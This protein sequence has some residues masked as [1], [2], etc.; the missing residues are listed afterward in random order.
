MAQDPLIVVAATRP[1]PGEASN[2]DAWQVDWQEGRCRVAIVDGLGHGPAAADAANFA[3]RALAERPELGPEASL[4]LC[5]AA[6]AGSRGAAMSIALID[7]VARELTYCGVGNAE[8]CL[9]NDGHSQRLIAYRGIIGARLPN[10]RAFSH[11]LTPDW[12]LVMYTDGI[13]SRFPLDLVPEPQH[14]KLQAVADAILDG[15]ARPT[16]DATVVVARDG[17]LPSGRGCSSRS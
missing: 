12:M 8:A 14:R 11:P 7:P 13:R 16:D 2:G 9:V 5:H 4:R 6:L 17:M 10:F 1:L 3:L 15:W